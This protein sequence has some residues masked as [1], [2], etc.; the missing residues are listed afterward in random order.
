MSDKQYLSESILKLILNKLEELKQ[1]SQEPI[2]I[3]VLQSLLEQA[4]QQC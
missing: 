1:Q 3:T 4:T 2:N